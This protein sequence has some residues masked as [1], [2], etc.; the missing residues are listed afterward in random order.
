MN[1][2]P[3]VGRAAV[4]ALVLMLMLVPGALAARGGGGGAG[5]GATIAFDTSSAVVGQE[6]HVVGSGF[7]PNTWVT[8]GAHYSDTTWWNSQVSDAQGRISLS[9]T[10]TSPGQVYHEAKQQGANGRLRLLATATLTVA[11]S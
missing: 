11:V 10:A 8:V 9:F 4:A 3:V 1:H 5:T 2:R 7:K 6:Y